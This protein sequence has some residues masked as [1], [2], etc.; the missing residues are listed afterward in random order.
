MT[1]MPLAAS[2]RSVSKSASCCTAEMPV[3]GSSRMSTRAPQPEQPGDLQL[4]ALAHRQGPSRAPPGRREA[5]LGRD[6]LQFTRAAA[7]PAQ[8][9]PAAQQ[10]VVEH[11]EGQEDQWILM[12]HARY[13]PR[14]PARVEPSGT[15]LP[16]R[17]ISPAS[18]PMKPESTFISVD[19]PAPFSPSN[20]VEAARLQA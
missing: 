20:T 10:E 4:L 15:G 13:R 9:A 8:P 18:A 16:S 12:E 1:L 17:T 7:G 11:G 14:W 5:E 19:L 2:V 6:A 3:V